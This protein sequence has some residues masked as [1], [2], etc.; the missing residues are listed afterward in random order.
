MVKYPVPLVGGTLIRDDWKSLLRGPTIEACPVWEAALKSV[1]RAG[2]KNRAQGWDGCI[3]T[4]GV[5]VVDYLILWRQFNDDRALLWAPYLYDSVPLCRLMHSLQNGRTHMQCWPENCTSK[6]RTVVKS[7][8]TAR[9]CLLSLS[10]NVTLLIL[11]I[12]IS[13]GDRLMCLKYLVR[14]F[15]LSSSTVS[16]EMTVRQTRVVLAVILSF[17]LTLLCKW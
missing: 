4:P 10:L 14:N 15:M 13:T 17:P 1:P 16:N 9:D 6:C 8:K 3:C 12:S 2:Q 7:L 5:H 11:V